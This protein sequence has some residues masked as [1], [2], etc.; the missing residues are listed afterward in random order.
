MLEYCCWKWVFEIDKNVSLFK[1]L[2]DEIIR[3]VLDYIYY[4]FGRKIF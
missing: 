2:F 1:E 4:I 3:V